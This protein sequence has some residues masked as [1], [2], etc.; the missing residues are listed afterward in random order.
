MS[1][2]LLLFVFTL[3]LP[4]S[5]PLS[6]PLFSLFLFSLS[7]NRG[8]DTHS[9]SLSFQSLYFCDHQTITRS[10][11]LIILTFSFFYTNKIK[12]DR[13]TFVGIFR[14]GVSPRWRKEHRRK[15]GSTQEKRGLTILFGHP[16]APLFVLLTF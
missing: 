2:S 4:F 12:L 16:G 11:S 5:S 15:V 8:S 14:F 7:P 3:S 1:A 13:R 10:I 9:S 6:H